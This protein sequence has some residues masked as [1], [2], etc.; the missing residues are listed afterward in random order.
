[1]SPNFYTF[2]WPQED[3][4]FIKEYLDSVVLDNNCFTDN[5]EG[6]IPSDCVDTHHW[7]FE[8]RYN[9]THFLRCHRPSTDKTWRDKIDL[10]ILKMA[11]EHI[12]EYK[13]R[14]NLFIESSA[15]HCYPE[16][17]GFMGWH[18]NCGSPAWR[19]Y[20]THTEEENK[21]YISFYDE[22]AGEEVRSYDKKGF[23][24]RAFKLEEEP[25][26]LRH[27]VFAQTKRWSLGFRILESEIIPKN[28]KK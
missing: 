21:S 22:E 1:M 26:S 27:A 28:K 11:K 10:L 18:T 2:D 12:E 5:P 17:D 13:D 19:I 25:N 7:T 24:L 14:D 4:Q 23:T 16:N 20:I 8:K 6:C 15:T 3:L 9:W